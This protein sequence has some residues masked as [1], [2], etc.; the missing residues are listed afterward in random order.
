MASL[1]LAD[2]KLYRISD[3][4]LNSYSQLKEHILGVINQELK[5]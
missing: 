2:Q 1:A 3:I 4:N 5:G